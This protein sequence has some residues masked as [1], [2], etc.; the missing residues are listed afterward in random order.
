MVKHRIGGIM[1]K[2]QAYIQKL[3]EELKALH[4]AFDKADANDPVNSAGIAQK[5]TE[6]A[7][8]IYQLKKIDEA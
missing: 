1:T 6:V 7:G 8:E 4:E 5:I 2:L 3:E